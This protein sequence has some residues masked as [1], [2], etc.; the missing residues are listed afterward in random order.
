MSK[1]TSLHIVTLL[2]EPGAAEAPWLFASL[3]RWRD[4]AE[5][6]IHA[7]CGSITEPTAMMLQR[8][9]VQRWDFGQFEIIETLK[10]YEEKL[11]HPLG[12]FAK[13]LLLE[14]WC[15]SAPLAEDDVVMFLDPDTLV[16]RPLSAISAL[17][18]EEKLFFGH[19]IEPIHRGDKPGR[20]LLVARHWDSE[21]PLPAVC[22]EVNT[23]V[24]LGHPDTYRAV[25]AA[26]RECLF[27]S[28]YLAILGTF[29]V[30]E[31]W[32]DQDLFRYFLYRERPESVGVLA[33]DTIYTT[34]HSANQLLAY[35]ALTGCYVMPDGACPAVVHFAGATLGKIPTLQQP[36]STL[37]ENTD[38]L[39]TSKPYALV[40][41]PGEQNS[42]AWLAPGA[43]DLAAFWLSRRTKNERVW[44]LY[45]P[46]ARAD[47]EALRQ[48]HATIVEALPL[49]DESVPGLTPGT[50][51]LTGAARDGVH[52]LVC[53]K[54][55]ALEFWDGGCMP[56]WLPY[57]R[58]FDRLSALGFRQFVHQRFDGEQIISMPWSLAGL[59]GK[60]QGER[61]FILGNGPSLGQLD[62]GCL[63]DEITFGSN[64]AYLGFDQWGWAVRYW[65]VMDRLQIERY[66]AEYERAIPDEMLKFY[67]GEYRSFLNF[68]EGAC[69]V[70]FDYTPLDPP[71][72]SNQPDRLH[73]GFTVTHMLMQIAAV[74]G[75]DPIILVGVDHRYPL[76]ENQQFSKMGKARVR[77]WSTGDAKAP[78]HFHGGYTNE[79]RLFVEPRPERAEAAFAEAARWAETNGRTILNATPDS[80][81]KAFPMVDFKTLF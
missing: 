43:R 73:L 53:P 3:R 19:E 57:E 81:L 27:A 75:C 40:S 44:L 64:R 12:K 63:K 25:L 18:H 52:L 55:K 45:D 48:E 16:Q 14:A 58:A 74:M 22:H 29:P 67:P 42:Y 39:S 62:M 56:D 2:E 26:Y 65:G 34:T 47:A 80:A 38:P 24:I 77:V 68:S 11:G 5:L 71:G 79:E 32:H 36:E 49:D 37:A 35:D 41:E 7:I 21:T 1:P 28:E 50:D 30:E 59:A 23:G 46:E 10:P 15:Q 33:L 72:F 8:E 51:V 4:E 70:P 78:T 13:L 69:P 17:A 20:R 76:T 54:T 60:H 6:H 61:A 31:H 9:E 66:G